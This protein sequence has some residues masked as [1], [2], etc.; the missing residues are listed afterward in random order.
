M[1]TAIDLEFTYALGIARAIW[2]EA[3]IAIEI[4]LIRADRRSGEHTG[5]LSAWETSAPGAAATRLRPPVRVNLVSTRSQAEV[6]KQLS[7]RTAVRKLDWV[8]MVG[9]VCARTVSAFRA[10]EPA[11][12]LRDAERPPD[13]GWLLRPLVLGRHPTLLFGDGGTGKSYLALAAALDIHAGT[14]LTGMQAANTQR[15]ALLDFEMDAWEHKGRARRLMADGEQLPDI[16]YVPCVGPLRD[17]VDRLRRIIRDQEVRFVVIDSVALACDG[18]PEESQAAIGFFEALR[19]LEVG[20]LL[21]AHVNRAGDTERPFGSTFWHNS[22]RAT[23]YAKKVQEAAGETL[24]I[25]LFNRKANT[26]ALSRPLGFRFTFEELRTRIQRTDVRDVP[27]LAGQV[28][29]KARIAHAITTQAKSYAE[30]AEELD[31]PVNSVV[32]TVRRWEGKAFTKLLKTPDG[33]HRIGLLS[34]V[35]PVI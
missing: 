23:W 19:R 20:S 8:G 13:A 33:V 32:Q 35:T 17:Q 3:Q 6:A 2:A 1:T 24:D 22:A 15:V 16:L 4:D 9:E 21:I 34:E 5:E 10:G 30:L 26:S 29:L 28:P 12:L 11:I 31:V 27:E 18:P 14:S 7:M 25:G